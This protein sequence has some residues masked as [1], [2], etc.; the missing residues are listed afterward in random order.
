MKWIRC[1]TLATVA[2]LG[3]ASAAS[4]GLFDHN[5][6]CGTT[7]CAPQAQ[8]KSS[9]FDCLRHK[10]SPAC[11]AAGC[12]PGCAAPCP[13]TC[14]PA[15]CTT[16]KKRGGLFDCFNR[17]K[18]A[19]GTSCAPQA[20][21]APGCAAP[22]SCAPGCTSQPKRGGLF[23]CLKHDRKPACGTAGCAPRSVCAPVSRPVC[24]TPVSCA[25]GGCTTAKKSG[26]LF[27]CLRGHNKPACGTACATQP[28]RHGLFDCFK[29]DK[30]PCGA[31]CGTVGCAPGH[32]QA[33]VY[34]PGIQKHPA[35]AVKPIEKGQPIP[36]APMPE[37]K[38]M[39]QA[40]AENP[41]NAYYPSR[42]GT[43]QSAQ[44]NRLGD[45]FGTPN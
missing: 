40:P 28:K 6:G 37:A 10:K 34:H 30:T 18:S 42:I 5:K 21:C 12:A 22:V 39:P 15:G 19:C 41:A 27:D 14:A 1:M 36:Q 44:Q 17:D 25:P 33:P 43:P 13:V 45:L 32:I 23:D 16:A 29:R 38:P 24:T 26:G 2:S 3:F 11:G 9:I 4:A 31:A 20:G 8:Q 35:P 7:G